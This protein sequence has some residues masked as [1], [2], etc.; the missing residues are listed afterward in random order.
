VLVLLGCMSS[1]GMA[2]DLRSLNRQARSSVVLLRCSDETGRE[3]GFGTGFVVDKGM[4]ITVHHVVAEATKV[5]AVT[6]E[7]RTLPVR[8]VIAEDEDLDL[9]LLSIEDETLP[10]LPLRTSAGIEPG[11]QVVVL[12]NPRGLTGTLSQGIVS[13]V[14]KEGVGEPDDGVWGHPLFQINAAISPGSSGS[15]VMDLDGKVI[16]VAVSQYVE[17]QNLNF[18]IPSDTVSRFLDAADKSQ[19]TRSFREDGGAGRAVVLRNLAIS[20][21]FFLVLFLVVWWLGRDR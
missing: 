2:E 18:A 5:E 17:G 3:Y 6:Q 20:A 19:L 10:P 9:A 4:V 12:G 11:E 13:A 15:P 1:F 21:G 8:G 14:R 16:G 7:E